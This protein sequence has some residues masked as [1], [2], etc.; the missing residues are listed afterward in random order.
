[1]PEKKTRKK[2]APVAE[3]AVE[4]VAEEK[5]AAGKKAAAAKEAKTPAARRSR[6]P[7]TPEVYVEQGGKQYN[8]S[9]IV[10]RAKA[11]YRETHKVGVQSCKIY[12]KPEDA[13]AYYLVNNVQG[14]LDL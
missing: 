5:S 11:D 8:I 7:V 4:T 2:A 9:D 6:P 14:K 1:M 12:V 3:A 13:A 10:E